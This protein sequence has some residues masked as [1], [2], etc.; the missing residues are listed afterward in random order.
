MSMDSG[1]ETFQASSGQEP[2]ELQVTGLAAEH[3]DVSSPARFWHDSRAL[4][5]LGIGTEL[6]GPP[7]PTAALLTGV[8]K[9]FRVAVLRRGM[10]L[11][12]RLKIS[13][14][15][16]CRD[17]DTR[18]EVPRPGHSNPDLA[19]A[20]LRV[21]LQEARLEVGDLDYL[22]GHTTSPACLAPP[23]I[24]FVADRLG[25]S[26]PYMELRQACTGFA[27][28]LVIAQGLAAIPR[29]KAVGIVGSETGSVYFDPQR[30]GEDRSQLVNLVMMGDGA[31]ALIVGPNDSGTGA[32]ISNNF[33]GHVGLGRE[34]GFALA[35]GGSDQPFIERGTLEF[36]HD[37]AAVR[38]RGPELFYQGALVARRL[39]I[40]PGMVDHVIPHQ[41][42]GRMA[43]LLGPFLGIER[44]QVFV[45]ARRLGNT[46]SAAMWLALAELRST[47]KPGAT[48][49]ALGTEATK[50]MFG[51]FLYVHG[52]SC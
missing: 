33:F 9:R 27:N 4:R 31:G 32:R 24:A 1:G 20:A 44:R 28:A 46:G 37:F 11:A 12:H 36:E 8:E 41:A 13:T 2:P 40:G 6:P 19:A 47:L 7:V 48:V 17:F 52:C 22:I 15:H 3:S 38:N 10:A 21:A 49:L 51:G 29:V 42:N 14:R 26:G 16:L 50:Y 5:V 43:E 23:N 18:H 30:A 35:A 39:G 45:N 34:P 25:F